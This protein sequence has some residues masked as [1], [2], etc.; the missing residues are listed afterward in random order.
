MQNVL[1]QGE[2]FEKMDPQRALHEKRQCAQEIL[3]WKQ[4]EAERLHGES[5]KCSVPCSRFSLCVSTHGH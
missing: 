5:E 2:F 4:L 1:L 3:S